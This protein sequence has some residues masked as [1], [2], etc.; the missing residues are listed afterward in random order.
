MRIGLVATPILFLAIACV[1]RERV[2]VVHDP[3]PTPAGSGNPNQGDVTI[4]DPMR[5]SPIASDDPDWGIK[6]P[7]DNRE[8]ARVVDRVA[9]MVNDSDLVR[10][11]QRRSLAL[12]NVTWEDTGRAQG[13]SLGPNISDLTLQVRRRDESGQF[14]SAIMPV[15]RPPNFTDR[16]G[17]VSSDRFFI[18]AGNEQGGSLRSI[19]LTDVLRNLKAFASHPDT[20][21]GNGNLL[22]GRDAHFLVSAQAVF[23]PI[24]KSGQAQFNPVLFNY[25][26][27]PGSPAVLSILVTRQGTSIQVVEN[28][29]EEATAAG[30]GQELYFDNKGQRA[31]FTAE[32]KS[33]VEQRITAQGGPRSEDDKSALQRGADVLF[34]VQVPLKHHNVGRL[35]GA[36]PSASMAQEEPM[37]APPAA[38]PRSRAAEK[39]DVEQ[40]VLGHGPN[41]GPFNEGHRLRLER[42]PAFPVRITVQFYKATSNGIASDIDL[43]AIA[44]SIGSVYEHADFVGSLVIPDGDPRRPTAWQRVPREWFPW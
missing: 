14:Q 29:P 23:L 4:A 44:R 42:D 39:S 16:T 8:Y 9:G 37:A 33:D 3:A 38:A 12:V 7:T 25:Q 43:D 32:R 15:I 34:L 31:A 27:A 1:T 24:P 5:E 18:R 10:R 17:D 30:W 36:L 2:I 28:R 19:A 26:S 41:L 21:L 13:S 22:A 6:E 40:A 20:I 35:G 11:V